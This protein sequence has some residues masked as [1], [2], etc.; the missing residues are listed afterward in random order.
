MQLIRRRSVSKAQ[1]AARPGVLPVLVGFAF[2]FAFAVLS[3]WPRRSA[4]RLPLYLEMLLALSSSAGARTRVRV[5]IGAPIKVQV[6]FVR[7]QTFAN[8]HIFVPVL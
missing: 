8:V 6:R 5:R 3:R 4:L 1:D 2:T 7:C